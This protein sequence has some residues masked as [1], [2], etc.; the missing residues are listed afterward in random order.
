MVLSSD[1][2]NLIWGN[3][4]IGMVITLGD[5]SDFTVAGLS[6]Q[7]NV[8]FNTLIKTKNSFLVAEC[9]NN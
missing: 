1:S 2:M 8:Q 5:T 3:K 6:K 9:I 7:P 4:I